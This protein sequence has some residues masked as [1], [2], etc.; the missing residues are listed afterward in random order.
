[1]RP[2]S[3]Q[4]NVGSFIQVDNIELLLF[5][6]NFDYRLDVKILVFV[7]RVVN[8]AISGFG[9]FGRGLESS[10]L[11]SLGRSLGGDR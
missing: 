10:L 11:G 3:N 2:H 6:F 5:V 8:N 7:I 9:L 4:Y 1:M